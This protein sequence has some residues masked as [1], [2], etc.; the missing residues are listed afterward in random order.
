M[1]SL[2]SLA[3]TDDLLARLSTPIGDRVER[4]ALLLTDASAAVRN[5]TGQQFT[6]GTTTTILSRPRNGIVRLPQRPV[7]A[8]T[9]VVDPN[10][11]PVAYTWDGATDRINTASNVLDS[12]SFEPWHLPLSSIT[13]T[14]DHGYAEIPDDLIGVVCQ[15]TGRA[16]G[17]P[18]EEA[19]VTQESIAGYSYSVGT[20]AASGPYGMLPDERRILDRYARPQIGVM[21][22]TF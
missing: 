13:V 22:V 1:T 8:V 20:A 5:Y 14:Y 10:G 21:S 2:P 15:I 17:R 9:S 16:L 4:A 3:T 7:T 18:V 19:G 6:A 11:N 12:W